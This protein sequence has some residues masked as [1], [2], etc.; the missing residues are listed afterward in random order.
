MR[1]NI[2]RSLTAVLALLAGM[3]TPMQVAAADKELDWGGC[4]IT[5]KAFMAEL[6]S[7]YEQETGVHINLQGG[8]AT[9]GI[10]G[11]A[12]KEIDMGGSCRMPLP[13]SDPREDRVAVHPVAWD[14]LTVIVH[15]DNPVD[16]ITSDRLRR[17]YLGEIT[18]WRELGGPDAPIELY[19]RN[20][21][22]SG[23]GFALRQYLF[24]D[25]GVEFA[26]ERRVPSSGPLEEAVEF[27]RFAM[28]VTG[29]SSAQKRDIKML[30][31]DGH[32]PNFESIK[33]GN[34]KMYR[35]LYLVTPRNMTPVVDHFVRFAQSREG[36]AILRKAGTVPYRDAP[37]LMSKMTI[38]GFGTY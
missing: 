4:G 6:A 25:T 38:Y 7:A 32:D 3:A 15:P 2:H 27:N 21:P 23:V 33:N 35:P 10:R 1:R 14:A 5:K 34:Y 24:E 19:V 17:V 20:S 8:G 37:E 11:V 13:M 30:E 29:Y 18:N 31:L 22:I 9:F 26:S 16:H 36:R 12:D 28:G